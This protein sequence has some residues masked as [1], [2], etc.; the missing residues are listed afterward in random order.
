MI[1]T[2]LNWQ[3]ETYITKSDDKKNDVSKKVWRLAM[4][5]GDISVDAIQT[6]VNIDATPVGAVAERYSATFDIKRSPVRIPA[7]LA[8]NNSGQVV[9]LL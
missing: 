8:T 5:I 4:A 1:R 6:T 3:V 2:V 9:N 7:A